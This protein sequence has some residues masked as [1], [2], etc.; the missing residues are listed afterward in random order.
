MN[1]LLDGVE[2]YYI[3][4]LH[5]KRWSG[6]RWS[7]EVKQHIKT[8]AFFDRMQIVILKLLIRRGSRHA[9]RKR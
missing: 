6:V 1:N 7:Q 2:L 5:S 4:D 3:K 9:A 8:S